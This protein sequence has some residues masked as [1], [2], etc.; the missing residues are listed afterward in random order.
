MIFSG[1]SISRYI[2]PGGKLVVFTFFRV[3]DSKNFLGIIFFSG[4]ELF[5]IKFQGIYESNNHSFQGVLVFQN[6]VVHTPV[7]IKNGTAHCCMNVTKVRHL[8]CQRC[9]S[10]LPS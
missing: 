4:I 7:W 5:K 9:P 3:A 10:T 8:S 2:F 6:L 1:V